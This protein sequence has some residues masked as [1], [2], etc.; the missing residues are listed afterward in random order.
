MEKYI[1]ESRKECFKN[2]DLEDKFDTDLFHLVNSNDDDDEEQYA[3]H[4]N[5]G[6]FTVLDRLTGFGWRDTETGYRDQEGKFWLASG[7]YDIRNK[8]HVTFKEAI[9]HIKNNANTCIGYLK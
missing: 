2:V 9:D 1:N 8:K 4:T 6:S 5:L 7:N 3:L